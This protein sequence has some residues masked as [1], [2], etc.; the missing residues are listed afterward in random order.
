MRHLKIENT[1]KDKVSK[2]KPVAV[3]QPTFV[4]NEY[5]TEVGRSVIQGFGSGLILTGSGSNLSGQAG[6]EFGSSLE[7]RIQTQRN[8][9]PNPDLNR[10]VLNIFHLFL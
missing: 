2:K 9:K 4:M 7:N 8:L 6:S 10:S 5:L 3:V 1:K